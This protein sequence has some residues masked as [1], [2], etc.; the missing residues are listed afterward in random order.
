[1]ANLVVGCLSRLRNEQHF[2]KN[3]GSKPIRF[4]KAEILKSLTPRH[5]EKGRTSPGKFSTYFKSQFSCE[6]VRQPT[7]NFDV[8]PEVPFFYR[9]IPRKLG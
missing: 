5:L 3:W 7:I 2:T 4:Q 1:M 6:V 8:D 9:L